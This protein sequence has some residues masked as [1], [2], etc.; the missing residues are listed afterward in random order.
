MWKFSGKQRVARFL[1]K[2]PLEA[3]ATWA[4]SGV[5][6]V[7]VRQFGTGEQGFVCKLLRILA[8]ATAD[9][10]TATPTDKRAPR[11]ISVTVRPALHLPCQ[12]MLHEKK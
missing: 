2:Y 3:I 7:V 12:V 10:V 5:Y 1:S 9:A 4:L 8:R 11:G 6:V